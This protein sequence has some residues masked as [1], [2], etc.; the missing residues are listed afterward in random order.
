MALLLPVENMK[1]ALGAFLEARD[2]RRPF[3]KVDEHAATFFAPTDIV[4][5]YRWSF[6]HHLM[7]AVRVCETGE[8]VL[9][10]VQTAVIRDDI[11]TVDACA[12]NSG[13]YSGHRQPHT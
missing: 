10:I 12:A 3:M 5:E 1:D 11:P 13:D 4:T 8:T 9:A 6:P 2:L 7:L